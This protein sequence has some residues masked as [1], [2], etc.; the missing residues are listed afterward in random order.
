ME[1]LGCLL[2]ACCSCCTLHTVCA[3]AC[4]AA[5]PAALWVRAVT[6][7]PPGEHFIVVCDTSSVDYSGVSVCFYSNRSWAGQTSVTRGAERCVR[8]MDMMKSDDLRNR[9]ALEAALQCHLPAMSPG[10]H[11]RAG[12]S[13]RGLILGDTQFQR[14]AYIWLLLFEE[15]K[16]KSKKQLRSFTSTTAV[17]WCLHVAPWVPA[18]CC[19]EQ[20]SLRS[21][22]TRS[23]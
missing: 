4:T 14:L 7:D 5:L 10:A 19:I 16:C 9:S 23:T 21:N 12:A 15:C 20:R 6:V 18:C 13:T 11:A 17:R 8:A 2:G 3:T 1:A 22:R